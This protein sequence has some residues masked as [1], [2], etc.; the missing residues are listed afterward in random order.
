MELTLQIDGNQLSKKMIAK[1]KDVLK[2]L[3]KPNALGSLE[4]N[5][6]ETEEEE[7]EDEDDEDEDDSEEESPAPAKP[8]D[9]VAA[10]TA[11]VANLKI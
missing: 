6:E 1:L 9:D 8:K 4:D 5:E 2:S 7:D 3:G 11:G 10:L